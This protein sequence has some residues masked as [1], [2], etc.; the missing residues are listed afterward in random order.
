MIFKTSDEQKMHLYEMAG[1]MKES[2]GID[3]ITKAVELASEYE[4]VYNLMALWEEKEDFFEE[5]E[6]CVKYIQNFID[7]IKSTEESIT[8]LKVVYVEGRIGYEQSE[9][10]RAE[11][12]NK[13]IDLVKLHE[14]AQKYDLLLLFRKGE[15]RV[16]LDKQG[17]RWRQR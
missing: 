9:K 17:Y 7:E 8:K 6:E 16:M 12:L 11:L 3:F 4:G 14:L 13:E 10:L 1:K 5:R 15:I 2:L